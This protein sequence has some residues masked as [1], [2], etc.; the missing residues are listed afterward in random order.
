MDKMSK[1]LSDRVLI[2]PTTDGKERISAGGIVLPDS[3][4]DRP[5]EGM[6]REIGAGINDITGKLVPMEIQVG[7][8]VAF[9][10]NMGSEI[11]IDSVD[12]LIM[13][14]SE[15]LIILSRKTQQDAI[16]DAMGKTK[17]HVEEGNTREI[18]KEAFK[19]EADCTCENN[20]IEN[21]D[22]DCV[23]VEPDQIE[24]SCDEVHAEDGDGCCIG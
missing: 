10:K 14:E 7:D 8:K 15:V 3:I 9:H 18:L 6:V 5:R 11:T 1:P 20:H 22:G 13:R 12:Y 4:K 17:G 24:C 21:V 16:N 19:E 2:E 23:G